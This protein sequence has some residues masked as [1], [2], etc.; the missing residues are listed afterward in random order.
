MLCCVLTKLYRSNRQ[1]SESTKHT[2]LNVSHCG[3]CLPVPSFNYAAYHAELPLDSVHKREIGTQKSGV[4]T[5]I[6]PRHPSSWANKHIDPSRTQQRVSLTSQLAVPH[7]HLTK[8]ITSQSIPSLKIDVGVPRSSI[9]R[10]HAS[11][12]GVPMSTHQLQSLYI[13][14]YFSRSSQQTH[15]FPS[16]LRALLIS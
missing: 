16:I 7:S 1:L 11:G 6:L 14:I 3:Y 5:N 13:Y 2:H 9:T 15:S 10:V 4:K 8:N 12:E